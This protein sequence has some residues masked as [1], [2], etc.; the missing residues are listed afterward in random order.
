[1]SASTGGADCPGPGAGRQGGHKRHAGGQRA[2]ATYDGSGG[3][4][5][6]AAFSVYS[7]VLHS[8]Q[9]QT[10]SGIG[11]DFKSAPCGTASFML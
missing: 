7:F 9:P 1:M 10:R 8:V 6:T 2:G 4:Q 11:T 5:K 3:G